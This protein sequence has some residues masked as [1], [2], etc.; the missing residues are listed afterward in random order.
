MTKVTKEAVRIKRSQHNKANPYF[1]TIRTTA[2]DRVISL[3]ARGLLWELLS[4]SDSWQV[5]MAQLYQHSAGRDKIRRIIKELIAARYIVRNEERTDKG[6]IHYTYDIYE[7]PVTENPSPV[8]RPL[9][10]TDI[11]IK[12]STGENP[13]VEGEPVS[14]PLQGQNEPP[15]PTT[16]LPPHNGVVVATPCPNC[17]GGQYFRDYEH[18]E[19]VCLGCTE[20]YP[21]P[22]IPEPPDYRKARGVLAGTED[23]PPAKKPPSEKQQ[24]MYEL[25]QAVSVVQWGVPLEELPTQT[26]K[27]KAFTTAKLFYRANLTV[28]D[29]RL[30]GE[31]QTST[32]LDGFKNG[33]PNWM[34][35]KVQ[36]ARNWKAK[37]IAQRPGD[38]H[39]KLCVE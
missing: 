11:D 22:A 18:N 4:R 32:T 5:R 34:I 36:T 25:A 2:Q 7:Q 21:V 8:N 31:W 24:A 35:G 14:S 15:A 16:P 12:D 27:D 37:Q 19:L 28:E 6:T 33:H 23:E 30:V 29:V 10:N 26:E 17:G 20:K 3:E 13:P 39:L 38:K 1:M 9:D